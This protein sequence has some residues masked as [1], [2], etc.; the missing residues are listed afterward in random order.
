MVDGELQ[1][2][3]RISS[4]VEESVDMDT[5]IRSEHQV[6]DPIEIDDEEEPAQGA[7]T[8]KSKG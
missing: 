3:N 5:H 1:I 8:I 2:Q 6:M 7:P 4:E